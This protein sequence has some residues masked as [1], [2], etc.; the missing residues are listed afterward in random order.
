MLHNAKHK[1]LCL[2]L[3]TT[4]SVL[5]INVTLMVNESTHRPFR[6]RDIEIDELPPVFLNVL[7]NVLVSNQ[8]FL[9]MMKNES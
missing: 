1:L 7:A 5:F 9:P 8:F 2:I 6:P 4:F 3:L